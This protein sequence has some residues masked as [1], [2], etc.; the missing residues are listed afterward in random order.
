MPDSQGGN[1]IDAAVQREYRLSLIESNIKLLVH[2]IKSGFNQVNQRLDIS[3]GRHAKNEMAVD[4]VR[5][6]MAI[7]FEEIE[8]REELRKL[9]EA[10]E[11]G[12]KRGASTA[13]ITQGQLAAII[14]AMGVL[15]AIATVA[16][17]FVKEFLW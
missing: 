3:N 7:S 11:G 15:T 8:Q 10:E 4:S 2:E 6:E 9:K 13:V 17:P 14:G 16:T 5:K 1:E 12:Y